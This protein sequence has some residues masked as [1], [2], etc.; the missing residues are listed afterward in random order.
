MC[1]IS[2]VEAG[3]TSGRSSQFSSALME[4]DGTIDE[5]RNDLAADGISGKDYF[6]QS[7]IFK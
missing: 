1:S 7:Q 3:V 4:I 6:L 5:N 2:P